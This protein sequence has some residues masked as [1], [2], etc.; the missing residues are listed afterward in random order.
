MNDELQLF[1]ESGKGLA[2]GLYVEGTHQKL[3]EARVS[4][5]ALLRDAG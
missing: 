4:L 1:L 3:G 2:V 5:K